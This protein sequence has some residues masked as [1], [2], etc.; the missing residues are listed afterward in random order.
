MAKGKQKVLQLLDPVPR[1]ITV[2]SHKARD[3]P[4]NQDVEIIQVTPL[5]FEL[6]IASSN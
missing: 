5:L 4:T 1:G 2:L 6:D 3:L